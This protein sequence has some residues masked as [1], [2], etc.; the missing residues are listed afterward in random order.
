MYDTHT[1]RSEPSLVDSLIR[2][3]EAGQR[4]VL[5]RLDLAY[6][7]LSQLAA[8]TLRGAA[9]IAIG[10]VLLSGS[11]FAVMGA[12]VV[13]LQPYLDLPLSILLVAG[14]SAGLGIAA[15]AIG[16]SRARSSAVKGLGQLAET[17]REGAPDV[18]QPPVEQQP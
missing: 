2:A 4:V 12:V 16:A 11:W 8:R 17:L 14:V 10:A 9:L 6:F 15:L 7:D 5:D 3:F 1:A 18:A 13:W